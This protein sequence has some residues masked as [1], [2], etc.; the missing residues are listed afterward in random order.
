[1]CYF[2]PDTLAWESLGAGY[3][4]WLSWIAEGGTTQ[5]YAS[6]RWTGW[7]AETRP[8]PLSHGITVYPFLWSRE[9]HEDLIGTT[10]GTAPMAELFALQDEFAARFAEERDIAAP[11][12]RVD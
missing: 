1:M 6:L 2:G 11:H 10:R 9:P 8:L 12:I 4:A 5:F 7:Q 3:G